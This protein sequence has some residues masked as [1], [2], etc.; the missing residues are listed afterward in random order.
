M[1]RFI[2]LGPGAAEMVT[3]GTLRFLKDAQKVY[4]FAVGEVSHAADIIDQ[5]GVDRNKVITVKV[6]MS[7]D[8]SK[9]NAVYDEL[10]STIKKEHEAGMNIALATEGDSSI[11]ATTHY[12]MDRLVEMGVECEQAPGIPSF[13]AAASIAGL[14]LVKLQER[15]LIIPGKTTSEEI[16]RLTSQ[17]Y[18]L[19]I[20]K[21]S[22]AHEAVSEAFCKAQGLD[23]HY[24]EN[25]G[26]PT[27]K[28][29]ILKTI[30]D[31]FP[32]FSLMIIV[33]QPTR[34]EAPQPPRGSYFN[35]IS[36]HKILN[37]EKRKIQQISHNKN[38]YKKTPPWGAG[39]L[40]LLAAGLLALSI[41]LHQRCYRQQRGIHRSVPSV[42]LSLG[43]LKLIFR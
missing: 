28:Y 29:E 3:L 14:H 27:Q 11:F 41:F 8:R 6:P 19:V 32:Y 9:A 13:I 21:L 31:S 20:M 2:S 35:S 34:E 16:L 33:P 23:F 24:F 4:C 36:N 26:M 17:G 30:P 43:T 25:I 18:N 15:L 10:A 39:G 40:P 38:Y 1:I 22:M 7:H 12:V 37:Y 5:L 42:R